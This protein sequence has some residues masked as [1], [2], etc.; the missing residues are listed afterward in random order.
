MSISQM[1]STLPHASLPR[2]WWLERRLRE[3]HWGWDLPGLGVLVPSIT[4]SLHGASGPAWPALSLVLMGPCEVGV[5]KPTLQLG[6][7]R[8][9]DELR[10]L[11]TVRMV[12]LNPGQP[13][14]SSLWS[15]HEP[16]KFSLPSSLPDLSVSSVAASSLRL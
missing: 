7:L 10:L 9:Q 8:L 15:P 13:D 16:T 5:R 12:E 11:L 14:S 2:L 3:P 6:K 1:E 4:L